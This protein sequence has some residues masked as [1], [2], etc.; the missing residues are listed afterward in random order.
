[1]T[2][3]AN[4]IVWW[5]S[6]AALVLVLV[7]AGMQLMR[8]LRELNR[9]KARVAGYAE[10]PVL[11]SLARAEGDAERLMGSLEQVAPLLERAEAAIAVIKRGPVPPDVVPAAKR[12]AAELAALRAAV[13]R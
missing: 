7:L 2:V 13:S 12:L 6:F 11:R 5:A 4:A 8:A 1:M 9:V 3:S 10:L